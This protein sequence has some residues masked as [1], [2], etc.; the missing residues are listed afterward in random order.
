M[1]NLKEKDQQR[2][3]L[4]PLSSKGDRKVDNIL[5]S[6]GARPHFFRPKAALLGRLWDPATN[7]TTPQFG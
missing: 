2:D 7:S 5:K 3:L 4:F 1:K 6:L